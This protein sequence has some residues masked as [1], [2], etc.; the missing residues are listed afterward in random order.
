MIDATPL[1]LALFSDTY[2]P[3][4]NGVARTLER[5][6]AAVEAR[7]GAVRVITVA[8]PEAE[9]APVEGP[10]PVRRMHSRPFWA[11]PQLRLAWPAQSA[12]AA[13]L[14]DFRPTLVHSATEFG[15]GMA[16]RRWAL[17]RGVPFVSSYHTNFTAY[18]SHYSLGFLAHPGWSFLRWFHN[19]ARRTYCPT[20]AIQGDLLARGFRRPHVWPRGVDTVRFSP[21][22]RSAALRTSLGATDDVL[23]V[24]YVGRLA[25]E[26]GVQVA[27]DALRQASAA[28]PGAIRFHVVGD[29]PYEGVLRERAPDGTRFAGRLQGQSLSEAYASGDVFIFPSTTDTFGNVLLEAMASGL[30]VLGAAVGPTEEVVG[31][32]AGWFVEPG[33]GPA[34][35]AALVQLVDD[36]SRLAQ[37]AIEAR[38]RAADQSWEAIWDA[39]IA[40][41]LMV[42][43]GR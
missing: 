8:D 34:F 16:G 4:V 22:H 5:L 24:T 43:H 38:Q 28:R 40:D 13:A 33:N 11:Y 26:K 35:A 27:L 17:Q 20:R 3:Q 12:V 36:R 41:Y 21:A 31:P 19:G 23:V 14:E 7:G 15:V 1:R 18:A 2:A 42:Q 6:V 9:P 10:S 32:R 29:G 37:A 39:L 25:S 30:P